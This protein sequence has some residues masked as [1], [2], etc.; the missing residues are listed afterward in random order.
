MPCHSLT[1]SKKVLC[2]KIWNIASFYTL[3]F[4]NKICIRC[5]RLFLNVE[6]GE[7]NGLEWITLLV[8]LLTIKLIKFCIINNFN[9]IVDY[10]V[11]PA[12]SYYFGLWQTHTY[13]SSHTRTHTHT[14][15]H[16]HTFARVSGLKTIRLEVPKSPLFAEIN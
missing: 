14:Y 3:I 2:F 10:F 11:I 15:T 9:I 13:T 16:I 4:G 8:S 1:R 12:V 7:L 5:L 6:F